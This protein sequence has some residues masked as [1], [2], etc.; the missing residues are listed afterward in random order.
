MTFKSLLRAGS[1]AAL[2]AAMALPPI[3]AQAQ[4]GRG[5]RDRGGE[6]V[7][8]RSPVPVSPAARAIGE[9]VDRAQRAGRVENRTEQRPARIE[10]NGDR[11]ARQAAQQGNI[12]GAR[13]IDRQSERTARQVEQRGDRRAEQVVQGRTLQERRRDEDRRGWQQQRTDEARQ[14]DRQRREWTQ[15]NDR[16]LR[17][18]RNVR[19][20]N[21]AR[22]GNDVRGSANARYVNR[23]RD[24]RQAQQRWDRNWRNDNRY[25]WNNYR[26]SNR[27][28]YRPGRYSSPYSNYAY[29]RLN[30]GISLNSLFFSSRYWINDPWQ[31]RLPAVYGSYRWVRYYDDVL[32]VDTYSGQV[33][34]VIYDFFW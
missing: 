10:Q 11:A 2:A 16:D 33:V 21:Q 5:G 29:R 23:A 13:Q 1:L 4:D 34:D 6:Q 27:N 17:S 18:D 26:Q 31:Y 20:R 8:R 12:R 22:P 7:N 3:A 19:D 24:Y 15:R 25:N 14:S 28:L 30:I 32:L 9:Q